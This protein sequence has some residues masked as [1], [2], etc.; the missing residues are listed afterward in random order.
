MISLNCLAAQAD[1]VSNQLGK[2][3]VLSNLVSFM[4]LRVEE[5]DV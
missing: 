4:K 5:L 1:A 3:N 2:A